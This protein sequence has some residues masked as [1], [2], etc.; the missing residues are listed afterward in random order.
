MNSKEMGHM[1]IYS[2]S[3]CYLPEYAGRNAH[4]LCNLYATRTVRHGME[5][6]GL[7]PLNHE[8]GNSI[9]TVYSHSI[10]DQLFLFGTALGDSLNGV[11]EMKLAR[12]FVKID[13]SSSSL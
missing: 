1:Y 11:E 2:Y 8:M 10:S 13:G 5:N 4:S 9:L 12:S 3:L 6:C 7:H